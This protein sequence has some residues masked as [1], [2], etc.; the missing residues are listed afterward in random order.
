MELNYENEIHVAFD[1]PLE[2]KKVLLYPATLPFYSVF[3]SA[4]E[5]L[6][7]SRLDEKDIRLLKLPYIDYMYEKSLQDKTFKYRWDMLA[8]ILKIVFGETQPFEILK[9][10]GKIVIRVYQRSQDYKKWEKE[11]SE[12]QKYFFE[13]SKKN[14]PRERTT[15][16]FFR[17]IKKN[18]GINVY[19][20]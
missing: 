13:Q 5:C 1:E 3:A 14:K 17:A 15:N 6:D 19:K 7:V 8:C 2:Y 4:D 11:Y 18:R 20:H 10:E 16:K 12:K 9:I